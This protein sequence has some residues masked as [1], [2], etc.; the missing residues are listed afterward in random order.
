MKYVA[1][2]IYIIIN[3]GILI[4]CSTPYLKTFIPFQIKKII[5]VITCVHLAEFIANSFCFCNLIRFSLTLSSYC[6]LAIF[7]PLN[8][9]L[10]LISKILHKSII[11]EASGNPLPV[12]HLLTAL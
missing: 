12:S 9:S 10:T 7:F 6:S 11:I 1:V 8:K 5:T 2:I 4:A 3:D